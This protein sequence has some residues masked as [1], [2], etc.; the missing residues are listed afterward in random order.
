M[1][2]LVLPITLICRRERKRGLATHFTNSSLIMMIRGSGDC[3]NRRTG[4]K[5]PRKE[6][7]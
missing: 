6:Y 7:A 2:Q 5:G 3:S 4:N 1:R